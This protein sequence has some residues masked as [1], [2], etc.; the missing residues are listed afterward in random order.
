MEALL[1]LS[2]PWGHRLGADFSWGPE[3]VGILLRLLAGG[4]RVEF[5][6]DDVAS[7]V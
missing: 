5:G 1:G 4:R 7:K 6:N 2:P 3:K